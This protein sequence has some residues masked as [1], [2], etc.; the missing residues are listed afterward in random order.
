MLRA[1]YIESEETDA[2]RRFMP[3]EHIQ[4]EGFSLNKLLVAGKYPSWNQVR[5]AQLVDSHVRVEARYR[6][7]KEKQE[8]LPYSHQ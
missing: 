4:S 7:L 6:E 1:R 2:V 8:L 3:N 5:S